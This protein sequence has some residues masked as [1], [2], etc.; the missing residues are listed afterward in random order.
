MD[1]LIAK[2]AIVP[3]DAPILAKVKVSKAP[4]D[5]PAFKAQIGLAALQGKA[6]ISKISR[7]HLV[8]KQFVKTC[9]D[10]ILNDASMLFTPQ[11]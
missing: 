10:T 4:I 2:H 3:Q 9:R 8:D 1:G 6:S 11:K 7:D 5:D